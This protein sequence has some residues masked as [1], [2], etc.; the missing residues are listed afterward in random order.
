MKPKRALVLSLLTLLVSALACSLGEPPTPTFI[1]PPTFTVP[2]PIEP[3]TQTPDPATP[4]ATLAPADA[5]ATLT[6]TARVIDASVPYYLER[7]DNDRLLI[8]VSHLVSFGTRFVNAEPNS[9]VTGIGGAR[10]WIISQFR[11]IEQEARA[12]SVP[13]FILPHSFQLEWRDLATTQ[14]NVL[15]YLPGVGDR[16]KEVIIVGAHYDS[17]SEVAD[18]SAPGADDNASGVAVLLECARIMAQSRHQAT[19]VFVAFSAQETGRQ[20]SQAFL[21]EVVEVEKWDVRAMINLDIVGAQIGANGAVIGDRVRLYSASPN[22]SISRQLARTLHMVASSYVPDFWVDVQPTVDREG[23]WGDHMTFSDSGYAA[24]RLTEAAEDPARTN[25]TRDTI[26]WVSARYM[27]RVARVVIAALLA[28]A[29]GPPP[30]TNVAFK[31][32]AGNP[33]ALNLTWTPSPNAA[34]YIIALRDAD[35]LAYDRWFQVGAPN[36]FT[37]NTE[38]SVGLDF[39]AVAAIDANGRQGAFSPEIP[40]AR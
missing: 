33:G 1:P 34:G 38:A 14:T 35:A 32:G 6:P 9:A 29:D 3:V 39:L 18:I 30:P 26:E 10:E 16:A 40:I 23:R 22:D 31:P 2:P 24:V 19:V 17:I 12:R 28:L 20:G 4:T 25:A 27:S 11:A 5:E 15:A 21:R 8:N 36:V 13:F 37:W 7:V